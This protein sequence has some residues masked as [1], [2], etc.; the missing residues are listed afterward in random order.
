MTFEKQHFSQTNFR[1]TSLTNC[2]FIN[3]SFKDTLWNYADLRNVSFDHCRFLSANFYKAC[4]KNVHF[5]NCSIHRSLFNHT[6]LHDSFFQTTQLSDTNFLSTLNHHSFFEKCTFLNVA[7]K[8]V[9]PNQKPLVALT[10]DCEKPKPLASILSHLL[11]QQG[12]IPLKFQGEDP[13][14]DAEALQI[15]IEENLTR[16]PQNVTSIAKAL[17]KCQ[18]P[19]I[20]AIRNKAKEIQ[21]YATSLLLPGGKDIEPELYGATRHRSTC[22]EKNIV[23]TLLELALLDEMVSNK[24]PVLGVCRG[25]QLINV[26][27]GGTLKQELA[28]RVGLI[29]PITPTLSEINVLEEWEN[30]HFPLRGFFVFSAHHQ[31]PERLGEGLYLLF[32]SEPDTPEVWVHP[33]DHCIGMQY[34]PELSEFLI[35]YGDFLKENSFHFGFDEKLKK[36]VFMTKNIFEWLT[37]SHSTQ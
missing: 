25:S 33:K 35:R 22:P 7:L 2:R 14:I 3:C 28:K 8:D 16:L 10:W 34:H 30:A 1:N 5:T 24:K 11:E 20:Q 6:S 32:S 4:L 26:F 36:E 21:S 31:S 27:Y 13:D 15:E 29:H 9:H 19:Q 23:K 37:R 17:L 18:T 12:A